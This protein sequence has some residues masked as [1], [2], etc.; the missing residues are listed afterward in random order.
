LKAKENR[1]HPEPR[2]GNLGEVFISYS[3]DSEDHVGR[4]LALS[5]RL[6]SEGIDCVLDQYETSPPEG[7]PRW[8]DRQIRDAQFVLVICTEDYYKR[9]M[10]QEV[11]GTGLGVR[12]EGGLIYQ[13]IYN[14]GAL[15]RK[16]LPV[17][18]D[19]KDQQFI[20]TPLQGAT[21][22]R[23]DTQD[24]YDELYLRL[25]DKPKVEKPS[26]GKRR[27]L[28][29]REVKTDISAYLSMP[30]DVELWNEAKWRSTFF[31]TTGG[32]SL[33]P[34]LGLGFLNEAPA[35]QIFEQWHRR[36]GMG[37]AFE[38]L[39]IS[40]I[41]GEV[42]GTGS[43][44]SVHVGPDLDNTIKRYRDA[45]L[46]VNPKTDLF[47]SVS[48]INRMNPPPTSKNLE[49]FKEAYRRSG[50]YLL[51]PGTSKP[52]GSQLK[53]YLDLGIVKHEIK[54]RRVEDIGGNDEDSVILQPSE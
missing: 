29:K 22:Y 1:C 4:V 23:V 12:W 33:P 3:W 26:L 27:A 13:H 2:P 35:R 37:D 6:R 32:N 16:F 28:P 20:P 30:I 44:Y 5:N 51:V 41:E 49:M 17:L 25:L 40:I 36:Y 8:M 54:L 24:G 48:R 31:I 46:K 14:A 47:V 21:R 45:G 43:G 18:L 39:R 52:D 11:E 42:P 10:G 38:E 9:V 7:W 50:V 53:P 19:P 15:N 34:V